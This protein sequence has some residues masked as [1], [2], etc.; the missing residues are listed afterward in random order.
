MALLL[1]TLGVLTITGKGP[2]SLKGLGDAAPTILIAAGLIA[3]G[4]A[5]LLMWQVTRHYR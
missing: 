2:A 3:A 4:A 1:P 5:G